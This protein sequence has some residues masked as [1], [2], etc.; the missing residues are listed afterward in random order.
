[1]RRNK[2]LSYLK[3]FYIILWTLFLLLIVHEFSDILES[4]FYNTVVSSAEKGLVKD[5][6]YRTWASDN[7]GVYIKKS[8]TGIDST[9]YIFVNPVR[10]SEM[11]LDTIFNKYDQF[12]NANLLEHII[13]LNPDNENI[14]LND[15]EKEALE[16]FK[17]DKPRNNNIT[18]P[19]FPLIPNRQESF[20][21]KPPFPRGDQFMPPPPRLSGEESEYPLFI[22]DDQ[23]GFIK[24]TEEESGKYLKIIKPIRIDRSCLTCHEE[25]GYIEDNLMAITSYSA[26]LNQTESEIQKLNIMLYVTSLFIWLIGIVLIE[27]GSRKI[28][29]YTDRLEKLNKQLEISK[30]N[31]SELNASKDKYFSILAHDLKN[32][33]YSLL[34]Y[35]EYLA[36]DYDTIKSDD[37][38]EGIIH[39]NNSSKRVFNL[40]EDLLTWNRVQTSTMDYNPEEFNVYEIVQNSLDILDER[41]KLKKI[42]LI[43]EIQKDA[44]LYADSEMFKAIIRN[45][46]S[47]AIKFTDHGGEVKITLSD[48]SDKIIFGVIDNGVGMEESKI[49]KLFRIDN[50][51][52]TKGTDQESGTGLGLIICKDMVQKHNGEIWVESKLGEGSKFYF[53][54]PVKKR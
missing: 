3:Y 21:D 10:M 36:K 29:H 49:E 28:R 19:G 27:F 22:A 42:S 53:S 39:C 8:N 13:V 45:L 30:Q 20:G 37:I 5:Y 48:N 1:M 16:Y 38:K 17:S 35:S 25:Q 31:L 4:S 18:R 52:S 46:T 40:L 50:S 26:S 34:S 41:A 44:M 7:G 47:N 33:F 32:S 15:I 6:M 24:I 51:I 43:N 12:G 9:D 23:D 11:M 2:R 14:G 54:I